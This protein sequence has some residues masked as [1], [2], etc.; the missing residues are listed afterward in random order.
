[1]PHYKLALLGFGNVGR[2]LAGLLLRKRQ[3]LKERYDITYTVTGIATARHGTVASPGGIDLTG[4]LE[5]IRSGR[6]LNLMT[7]TLT[8]GPV[9]FIRK[10]GA[11]VLFENTPVNIDTGQPGVEHLR[12]ALECGMHAITANKG[13]VVHAYRELTDL[14]E[15][16]GRKFYFESTVMDGAPIFSLFRGAIPAAQLKSFKGVLNSTTNIILT[17]MEAGEA[18]ETAVRYCQ[19]IGIAETNP[20]ADVDGWDAAIKVAALV[21][22]LMG[23]PLKPQQVERMGIRGITPEMIRSAKAGGKRYKL[24]C[25][26]ERN[27]E[28]LQ[29]RV[30]PELVPVGSPMYS[31]EGSTSIV[32]FK[33]DVLGDLSIVE[34]DPGPQTTAYG[35]LADFINAVRG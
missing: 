25:S 35:L 2:A 6:T 14:A 20:S 18:F 31:V 24:V 13:P 26:A 8:S 23:M 5:L 29:A 12:T 34:T 19:E 10:C 27:G 7:K 22:V 21:T 28:T 1:M 15:S 33:T 17:R 9:D 3:E 30:A 11:D 16:Q 4:A 32:T